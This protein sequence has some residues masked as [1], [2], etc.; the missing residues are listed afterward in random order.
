MVFFGKGKFRYE[1]DEEFGKLP[2]GLQLGGDIP[3]VAVDSQDRV[4]VFNRSAHPVIVFARDG[5][6]LGSWGEGILTHPHGIT[7]MP[8]DSV[9]CTDDFDHTVRKFTTSGELLQTIGTPNRPSDTGYDKTGKYSLATI[10]RGGPP[11]NR[12][13]K[14]AL[15][16]NGDLYVTDGYGN[17]RVH[18]FTGSGK[19]IRSWGEPGEEPGHFNLP[20]SVWSHT[21]GRLFVCDRENSRVQIFSPS[22][23]HL[24]TWNMVGRPQELLIDK[25]NTVFM[26]ARYAKTGEAT[27]AGRVMTETVPSHISIRDLDG[28]VLFQFGGTNFGEIDSFVSAHAICMDSHGD[29]YVGENGQLALGR[30]GIHKPGYSSLRKLVRV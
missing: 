29:I 24:D 2:E 11:F 25:D 10:Q 28:N 9:Y 30:L 15:A 3:G 13:T 27:M 23:E 5:K 8:D 18:H 16:A 6:F 12:P 14:V 17:A 22:G 4:Y 21:D 20:H 7:I 19:L 26:V 1:V